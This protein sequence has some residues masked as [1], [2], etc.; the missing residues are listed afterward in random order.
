MTD[1]TAVLDVYTL[2]DILE[3]NDITQEEAL[4]YLVTQGFLRLPEIE[5]L[6]FE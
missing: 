6:E 3:R 1:Y 2:E 4:D 5:P